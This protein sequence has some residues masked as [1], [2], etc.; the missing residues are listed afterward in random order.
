M[1]LLKQAQIDSLTHLSSLKDE[2]I[3]ILDSINTNDTLRINNYK[4]LLVNEKKRFILKDA[5]YKAEKK[6][7]IKRTVYAVISA[8]LNVFFIIKLI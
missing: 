5:D 4:R 1:L 3:Y 8:A 7:A 6:K 2:T